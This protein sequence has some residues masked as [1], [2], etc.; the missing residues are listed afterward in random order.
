MAKSFLVRAVFILLVVPAVASAAALDDYYL[1]K[2]GQQA[3]LAQALRAVVGL[4]G[5]P[6]ER[7]RTHLYRSLKRDFPA[8]EPATQKALGKYVSRPVLSGEERICTP[9][10][11]HFNIH[12]AASGADAPDPTDNNVNGVPDWVET[13]AGVFE[14]VYGVEV[15]K[16]GYIAP[17]GTKYDVYLSDLTAQQAYGFTTND[18]F[19]TPP[20]TS[21]GTYIEIDRAFTHSMFTESGR[22]TPI[23]ML[24]ITAAHEFHHAI[25]FAYNYYFDIWYGEVTATW[26]EDEVYNSVN[27]LYSYLG[28]YVTIVDTLSLNGPTGNNTEY[29][30][31]IFNRFLAEAQGSRTVVR[32]IWEELGREPANSSRTDIPMLPIVQRVLQNNLGNNFFGF[33]KK[34]LV[35]DWASAHSAELPSIPN[36]VPLVTSTVSGTITVQ[37]PVSVTSTPYTFGVY[38]YLPAN[39]TGLPLTLNIPGLSSDLAVAAFRQDSSGW[40]EYAYNTTSGS[41]TVPA[42]TSG[43]TVYL[44]F[45]NNGGDMGNPVVIS[46][47]FPADAHLISDGTGLDANQLVIPP[48]TVV[49]SP[50]GGG[51]GGCFIATAA[52]GSYLHPKVARLRSFRDHH[53]LTNAPGRLFVSLYYRLSPPV[54][55]VIGEHEWMRG[56]VRLLLVPLVLAVEHPTGALML[57]LV[58]GGGAVSRLARRRRTIP[59]AGAGSEGASW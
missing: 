49:S 35:R 14:Y 56:G 46:P 13:V 19:P 27:Q 22:Y 38:R 34:M 50:A 44:L 28:K 57:L 6:A 20:S 1:S 3:Q 43:S 9:A 54:A 29:G 52:Y 55:E 24:Q 51:G 5:E 26:M 30:R 48:V 23:Q 39:S 59:A 42:F 8:L 36:V 15:N 47:A 41:V 58:A 11:G 18:G 33:A 4:E 45:C 10:G 32:S 12:Y 37:P 17:P 25:Q 2:F 31:W 7:C 16:M 53:L 21:V 40:Q